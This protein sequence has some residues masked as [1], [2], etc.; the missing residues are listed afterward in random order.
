MDEVEAKRFRRFTYPNM[1]KTQG[2]FKLH[3]KEGSFTDSE[4][5]VLLG[6]LNPNTNSKTLT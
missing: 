2:D 4:I 6:N 5:I 3:V 1:T